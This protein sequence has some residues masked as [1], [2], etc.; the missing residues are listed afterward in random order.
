[1]SAQV[2]F[3]NNP[4]N[5]LEDM[6]RFRVKEVMTIRQFLA[7]RFGADFVEFEKP[8]ALQ[9]NGQMLM[10]FE[11]ETTELKEGDIAIFIALPGD[12]V[13]IIIAI[14]AVIIAVV[15]Y[16]M[17]PDPKIPQDQTEGANTV[18]TLR[19]Q[20]NQ[21]RPGEPIEVMYGR[22][23]RWPT[24]IGKPYSEYIGNQQYQY[25]LLCV[26][27]GDYDIHAYQ[28]DDTNINDF[29]EVQL[30][31]CPPGVDV[32]LV[33][34]SVFT[35]AEVSNIELYGPNET[36]YVAPGWSGPFTVNEWDYPVHRLAVDVSFPQGLYGL[37]DKGKLEAESVILMFE[38]RMIGEFGAP[39]GAWT[40]LSNPMITRSDNTPQ[41]ITYSANV[42]SGRYEVRARRIS[43]K[44]TST[45]KA[46]Q[47]RWEA[48][49]AYAQDVGN[50][51]DVFVIAM[52]A[53]A[54]NNL[55]DQTSR[56][57]NVIA[58]R[59]L[60]AWTPG[61]G[62][63]GSRVATRNPVWAF[64]DVFRASYGAKLAD[65]YLDLD[66]LYAM[67]VAFDAAG[68]QFDWVFDSSLTVWEA[69]KMI[70]RV[71]RAVPIPRGS[72]VTAVR[73]IPQTLPS[74]IFNQHNI[75]KGTLSKKLAMFDFQPFD[76]LTVE[77]TDPDTWRPREV[78]CILPGR[79]GTNLDRMKLPGVTNRD[80]AFQE[81]MYIQS[82]K[83]LQRK[84]VIFQTGLEGHLPAYLDL[85]AVSHDT[86]RVGQGGMIL[87]YDSSTNVMTLSE[88]VTFARNVEHKIGIRGDDGA[89]LGSPITCTPG[90][91]PNKVVLA[92]DPVAGID[93]SENR[94]PPLYAFGVTDLW[95]F[96]GKVISIRPVDSKSVELTLVN[97]VPQSYDY[98]ESTTVEAVVR[99][100]IR[101]ATNPS[102]EWVTISPV[103]DVSDRVYV[104]WLPTPGSAS[105]MMQTS[106][107][108]GT[109]WNGIVTYTNPPIQLGANQGTLKVR[110]AP[111][112]VNGNV[113]WTN[114]N[115]YIVGS[116]VATP[117]AVEFLA[118]QDAFVGLTVVTRWQAVTGALGYTVK[119]YLPGGVTLL[120]AF[121]VGT[122][123]RADYTKA[124]YDTDTA[125]VSRSV[126]VK[127]SAY[128]AG[129]D[130]ALSSITRTNP[131]PPAPTALSVGAPTGTNYPASWSHVVEGDM[132]EYRVYA[133]TTMGFTPGVGNLVATRTV[134]NAT[135]AAPT[136][137]VYWRVGAVDVWGAE[138]VLSA[139]AVIP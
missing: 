103:P 76:G 69:A 19:G 63:S 56:S 95:T 62:W 52:R 110:I 99:P 132:K 34:S 137:P 104:D 15:A 116:N 119:I 124:Q 13:S 131:T 9:F 2:V 23:R 133:S 18:Y 82:R 38:Y 53:L 25:S 49:K 44:P 59:K 87:A 126:E 22:C 135:I 83:E 78:N 100:I 93:F 115:S 58:T 54:T 68:N 128:N 94:V 85:V 24:Y 66:T 108:D 74:A 67:S 46:T 102:V 36:E 101:N 45:R 39:L 84:T 4:F 90:P 73:D 12:P 55:N 60:N 89:I 114:S 72:L 125:V 71:G 98:N 88:Q 42:A 130:G 92:S 111:F 136:R 91:S 3:V 75:I 118:V 30:Q 50:F 77:Y 41:R 8:T 97:Y 123:T 57:F 121:D 33:E 107:D 138:V 35:S 37:D 21:F 51:G 14:V 127:V 134:L 26:G 1:M 117:I 16:V 106:Y 28:L 47:A 109:T 11:W 65:T 20:S 86:V 61:G 32:T 64:C 70:M 43:L 10:R 96:L 17:M 6:E 7:G 139:E 129:G 122:A 29:D 48:A 120:R 31:V 105:Y 5:P 112:S 27:Q 40:T 80:K 81:G 79:A 113:I